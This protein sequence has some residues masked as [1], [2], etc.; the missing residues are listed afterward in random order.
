MGAGVESRLFGRG[1][2]VCVCV[3]V[4]VFV[5]VCASVDSFSALGKPRSRNCL[6][7]KTNSLAWQTW[8]SHTRCRPYVLIHWPHC[9]FPLILKPCCYHCLFISSTWLPCFAFPLADPGP[10]SQ[11]LSRLEALDQVG[12][13]FCCASHPM[14]WGQERVGWGGR[15]AQLQQV[16]FRIEPSGGSRQHASHGNRPHLFGATPRS[17]REPGRIH[18]NINIIV[19]CKQQ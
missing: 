19:T 11:K 8:I 13:Q 16:G 10:T 15:E 18:D 3:C 4:C 7:T 5:C 9:S 1:V 12:K 14:M 2:C 6:R 17:K